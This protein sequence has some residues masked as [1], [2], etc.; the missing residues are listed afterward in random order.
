[1]DGESSEAKRTT[2]S[3]RGH[4]LEPQW[5]NALLQSLW[6]PY[7]RFPHK[8]TCKQ[9]SHT[10]KKNIRR[11]MAR[12]GLVAHVCHP[13]AGEVEAGRPSL[14]GQPGLHSKFQS[15]HPSALTRY[16]CCCCCL[17]VKI[18]LF[19][20]ICVHCSCLQTHKTRHQIPLQM[21]VSHHVV[22]GN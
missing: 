16:F 1:M 4:G 12:A 17:F 15:M 18:Y 14:W 11:E 6:V 19:S 5:T 2:C 9:I 7:M 20:C 13:S 22:A 10:R 3:P 21:V 8:H